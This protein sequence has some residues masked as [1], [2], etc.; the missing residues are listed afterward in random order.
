M[1]FDYDKDGRIYTQDIGPVIRAVGLKPTEEQVKGIKQIVDDKNGKYR[2][3]SPLVI[4]VVSPR[5][6]GRYNGLVSVPPPL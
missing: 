4:L 1:L 3:T 6:V 2:S 5:R